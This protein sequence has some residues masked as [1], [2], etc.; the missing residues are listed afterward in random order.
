ML[1]IMRVLHDDEPASVKIDVT[2]RG[3]GRGV[4]VCS[5]E[6]LEKAVKTR[7]FERALKMKI[8]VDAYDRIREQGL[9]LL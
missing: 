3:A 9:Q 1:R 5:A 7:L 8:D 6:C 2:G 4:Y